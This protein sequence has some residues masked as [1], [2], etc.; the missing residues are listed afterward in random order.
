MVVLPIIIISFVQGFTEFLPIS[1][2]GH[3]IFVANLIEYSEMEYRRM[4][5]IAHFGSLLAIVIYNY[6]LLIKL[7]FSIN[8][9]FRTDLDSYAQLLRNLIIS[10]IPLMF[11]GFI[12]AN[13]MSQ[14]H[15]DSL[16]LVG[17]SSIIFGLLLYIVDT[18]CL[19]IKSINTLNHKN[20]FITGLFQ[21]FAIIPGSSRSGMTILGL[22]MLG[23]NRFDAASYSNILSI[24]AITGAVIFYFSSEVQTQTLTQFFFNL[25]SLLLFF[26]SFIFSFCF[27]HLL[28]TWVKKNTFSIFIYYRI[29]FGLVLL[30]FGYN[31]NE[32]YLM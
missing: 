26:F 1:S 18:N 24:P 28:L 7:F 14:T 25:E 23:F 29:L 10:S 17:F 9:F 20:A 2:Q 19:T 30:Y 16:K 3:N 15:L 27:I 11:F 32:I 8:N 13:Y 5:I 6:Q 4:N 31:L 12:V 22:R 21:A